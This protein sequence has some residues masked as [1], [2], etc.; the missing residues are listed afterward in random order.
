MASPQKENGYTPIAN[1]LLEAL[2]GIRIAG[3]A[4]QILDVIFRK[5]YG[6]NKKEDSIALSQFC[7]ITK[8]GK[9][10]ICKNLNKLK[11]MNLIIT[12]KGNPHGNIYRIN[13]DF[14]TW[15]PL[16]KK[17]TVTNKGN[18]HYQKRKSAL[19]KKVHTKETITKE[20]ITKDISGA[21]TAVNEI[22][23]KFEIVNPSYRKLFSNKTQRA[24]AERLLKEHGF[25]KLST[26]V[27]Y[28]PKTNAER[29]APTITTPLQL[30]DKLGQLVAW[31]QKIKKSKGKGVIL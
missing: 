2:A 22:I 25:E 29:Y 5:T 12:Q 18:E 23:K 3:E 24:A 6:F 26:M 8:L 17:V 16:P 20:T 28:L 10:S 27:A 13:K 14:D 15:K 30:E 1:E 4:R 7:L 21:S 11:E 9:V 19:P 31:S